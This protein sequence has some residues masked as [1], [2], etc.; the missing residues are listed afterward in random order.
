MDDFKAEIA[1]IHIETAFGDSKPVVSS[2]ENDHSNTEETESQEV[3]DE[4]AFD[5]STAVPPGPLPIRYRVLEPKLIDEDDEEPEYI[6]IR[7]VQFFKS[8][9][10]PLFKVVGASPKRPSRFRTV[11]SP[12]YTTIKSSISSMAEIFP[13]KENGDDDD[14]KW[15]PDTVQEDAES[16]TNGDDG[17]TIVDHEEIRTPTYKELNG[18]LADIEAESPG[19]I[20]ALTACYSPFC[21]R[22]GSGGQSTCYSFVCPNLTSGVITALT[23]CYSPLC[24]KVGSGGQSGCYSFV[25]PGRVNATSSAKDDA[26]GEK[27]SSTTATE[28]LDQDEASTFVTNDPRL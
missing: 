11:G 14:G 9:G 6:P 18:K 7:P 26:K 2:T 3:D 12:T 28:T 4:L 24:G 21:D 19:V 22:F 25:C 27:E 8:V 13:G 23:G 15:R 10:N 1:N 20:T 16:V 5:A 17:S